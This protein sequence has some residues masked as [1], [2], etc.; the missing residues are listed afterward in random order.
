MRSLLF[1]NSLGGI[2]GR[3]Y[4]FLGLPQ[5]NEDIQKVGDGPVCMNS[6]SH[7]IFCSWNI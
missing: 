7:D 1:P 3:K 6:I 4:A 5:K 2:E